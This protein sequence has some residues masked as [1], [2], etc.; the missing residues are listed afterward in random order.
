M[1]LFTGAHA[2]ELIAPPTTGRQYETLTFR[3]EENLRFANP[4]DLETNRVELEIRSPDFNRS[5]LSFF[6]DGQNDAGVDRWVARFSPEQ[7]GLYRFAVVI[8]DSVATRFILTVA[9][10]TKPQ[11]GGL[12][13]TSTFGLFAFRSGEPFRGIG[14]NVCWTNDYARYF[15]KMQAAGMNITRIWL[16]PWNLSFE[17][18]ETG[19]GRYNLASA[20]ALDSI[21]QLAA[22]YGIYVILCIDYHGVAPKGMGFFRENRWLANPYNIANGG[23]CRSPADMF[24]NPVAAG[25]LRQKYKYIAA[26][27]GHNNAI[28]AWEFYNEADLM[29]GTPVPMNRWHVAMAEFLRSI[30]VHHRLISTSGTRRFVEKLVDAF[31]SPAIDVVMYHDYNTPDLAPY[32]VDLHEACVEY[33]RKP[34]V[35]GEFGVEFRGGDLTWIADSQHVG[36]HNGL[37][38]GWFSETPVVPLS[39]WWDSYIE[40]HDLWNEF[41]HLSRF[42]REMHFG[43]A[44]TAFRSLPSGRVGDPPADLRCMVRCIFTGPDCA[45]WFKQDDYKWSVVREG[46][47][48]PPMQEFIQTVPDLVPGRYAIRWYDPGTGRF[49]GHAIDGTATDDGALTL[50][51]PGFSGDSACLIR[52]TQ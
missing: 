19:L 43:D 8:R 31:R 18:Q 12:V 38:A 24:T 11:Q 26:R 2:V 40:A 50:R 3:F 45:L 27:Y 47:R 49:A 4:F 22:S 10:N 25:F 30:D 15:K 37:W 39:W 34:L 9:R 44:R 7:A 21:L 16:C 51:V 48:P 33:Y 17:W 36:L 6:F 52:R 14:M 42:A 41:E 1:F 32:I 28:A 20:R 46:K 35:L 13:T 29:A 5:V 23:P